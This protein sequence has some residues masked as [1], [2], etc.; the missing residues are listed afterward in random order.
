MKGNENL[1]LEERVDL[2]ICCDLSVVIETDRIPV[3]REERHEGSPATRFSLCA[4]ERCPL[5]S[6]ELL[7]L[8]G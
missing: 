2:T 8:E 6:E 1:V 7:G 5:S 4:A 3:E